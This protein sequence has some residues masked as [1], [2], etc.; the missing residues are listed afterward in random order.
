MDTQLIMLGTGY[1]M[2]T[3]CYNTCFTI[4]N[5]D[6]YFLIDAG[7]GNGIMLQ[8]DKAGIA[9][10]NIHNMFITHGHTDHILGAIWVI[11]KI[12][13]LMSQ[14]SYDGNFNIYCH[15]ELSKML[16]TFCEMTLAGK[17]LRFIGD[18]IIIHE[19]LD[20]TNIEINNMNV[21]FF[22]IYSTKAKQF[23]FAAILPNGQKLACLGDEPYNERCKKYIVNSDWML[24]EAFCL[25]SQRDIFKPYEKHH[26]TVLDA[27][28]L[29]ASLKIKNLVLYHTEDKNLNSRKISY[30]AEAEKVFDGNV[31]VPD[32]LEVINF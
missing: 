24:C 22:D 10:T 21:D 13:S 32:D 1:A 31:F 25:Y 16:S 29:A 19:V 2:A 15:N 27:G 3:K 18:R 9:F 23:G 17:L 7:G 20:G 26:S 28:K 8:L 14:E 12:A 30:T 11:R 6:D 5:N 4:K